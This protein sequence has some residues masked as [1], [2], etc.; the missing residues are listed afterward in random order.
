MKYLFFFVLLIDC[1][2]KE[3]AG[4][5]EKDV[6]M[7]LRQRDKHIV[8]LEHSMAIQQEEKAILA[9]QSR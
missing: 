3:L 7:M 8:E 6:E 4:K 9:Q 2:R 1:C 5:G